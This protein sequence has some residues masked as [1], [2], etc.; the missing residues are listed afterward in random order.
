MMCRGWRD[1]IEWRSG[2]WG[3]WYWR[4]E[5]YAD[6]TAISFGCGNG[7]RRGEAWSWYRVSDD[8]RTLNEDDF[9]ATWT[10]STCRPN[11]LTQWWVVCT[12]FSFGAEVEHT[13]RRACTTA[14]LRSETQ[15]ILHMEILTWLYPLDHI[16]SRLIRGN[17]MLLTRFQ[18]NYFHPTIF[19][20]VR[21]Y[22]ESKYNRYS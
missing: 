8:F 6:V 5:Y 13:M 17:W 4:T 21:H 16:R 20:P 22:S 19:S 2:G 1:P 15:C 10:L 7:V 12:V 9:V 14:P 11:Y 18:L 3:T